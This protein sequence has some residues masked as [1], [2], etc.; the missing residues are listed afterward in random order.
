MSIIS[1]IVVSSDFHLWREYIPFFIKPDL[2]IIG[3][4][5]HENTDKRWDKNEKEDIL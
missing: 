2:E 3:I 5:S 4:E 1:T